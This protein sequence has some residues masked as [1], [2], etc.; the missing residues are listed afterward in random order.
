MPKYLVEISETRVHSALVEATSEEA[1]IDDLT[2]L[3]NK[4]LSEYQVVDL[5]SFAEESKQDAN[6]S[7]WFI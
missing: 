5:Q 7:F 3:Y 6:H 4:G 1:A 2:Q